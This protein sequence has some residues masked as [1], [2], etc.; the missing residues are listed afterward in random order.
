VRPSQAIQGVVVVAALGVVAVVQPLRPFLALGLVVLYVRSGPRSER[1][2][3]LGASLPVAA[4][5]AWGAIAQPEAAAAAAQCTDVFAPPAVWRFL[6]AIV[7][8]AMLGL[9]IVERR[10]DLAELGVRIGSPRVAVA[11][12]VLAVVGVPVALTAATWLGGAALGGSFFGA[13]QLD[14]SQPAALVPALLFAVS[15][16]FA[17]EV[18]Y[19]GALMR[20]LS[21]G[22]G[23]VGANLGQA[24]VFG[25]AHTGADFV[26]SVLPTATA[27]ILAGFI[28]GAIARRSG[29]LAFVIA[30]H[31]AAD[32]PI[33]YFWACRLA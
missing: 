11:G 5:L 21:P 28:A 13:Y 15:N 12:V 6:E 4:I 25:L 8:V 31:A 10:A 29:S 14:L 26:G 17:E 19:R 23:I 30:V 2:P 3:A 16:A 32:I 7:G 9:L 1:S 24:V 18:A 27:M 22:I 33:Y 20:W